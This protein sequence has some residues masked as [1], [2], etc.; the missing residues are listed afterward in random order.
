M[1]KT[2]PNS[3]H[4]FSRSRW[5]PVNGRHRSEAIVIL[6]W[7]MCTLIWS[8]LL[9]LACIARAECVGFSCGGS[10]DAAYRFI[11]PGDRAA[12]EAEGVV[13]VLRT[14]PWHLGATGIWCGQPQKLNEWISLPSEALTLFPV[15]IFKLL[16]LF[17]T[18]KTSRFSIN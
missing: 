10:R 8:F 9:L 15:F 2:F 7:T 5:I 1:C 14:R 18:L 4:S 3:P 12:P 16:C 17:M 13:A 6:V 11:E